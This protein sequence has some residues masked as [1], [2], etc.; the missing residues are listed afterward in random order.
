MRTPMSYRSVPF[1]VMDETE[2]RLSIA[3]VN[4][5]LSR[6]RGFCEGAASPAPFLW[7]D[8]AP[9]LELTAS[10]LARFTRRPGTS[11][12]STPMT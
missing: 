11:A 8:G 3:V 10:S 5:V 12:R 6:A 2:S 7:D 1:D 4:H 9:Y